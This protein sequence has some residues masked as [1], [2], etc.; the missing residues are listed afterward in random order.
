M[1]AKA[2]IRQSA[3]EIQ[4]WNSGPVYAR[5]CSP[6][7]V[8]NAVERKPLYF[9]AAGRQGFPPITSRHSAILSVGEAFPGFILQDHESKQVQWSPF[10]RGVATPLTRLSTLPRFAGSLTPAASKAR[11]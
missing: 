5:P 8:Q 2:N 1:A 9:S 3:K 7:A 10:K 4:R 11:L 6:E